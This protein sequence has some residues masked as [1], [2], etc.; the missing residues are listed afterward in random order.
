[1][2]ERLRGEPDGHVLLP[3]FLGA[4]YIQLGG[5]NHL[6]G[7]VHAELVQFTLLGG[8]RGARQLRGF[9][10]FVLGGVVGGS[11]EYCLFLHHSI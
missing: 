2:A 9:E 5:E 11:Q 8:H 1:M 7:E 10:G 4:L 3:L 6:L